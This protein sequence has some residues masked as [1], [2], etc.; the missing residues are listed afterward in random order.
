LA[1]LP[2]LAFIHLP[3][4][5]AA[6]SSSTAPE[7]IL[8]LGKRVNRT[9]KGATNLP[10]S[11]FETPQSVSV[12]D[13]EY[14]DSFGFDTV[15][16]VLKLTTGVNVEEVETDRTYY[17]ARGF[18][19]KSMQVD[20]L[21]LPFNWNVVGA[22]D[23]VVYDRVE[24]IRG[25]NGLLTG[26]GNPS[27]TINYVRKRPTNEFTSSTEVWVDSEQK[28]RVEAD[29][30]GPLTDSG[31]WAARVVAARQTGGS[32]LD[33]YDN[34]R[35]TLYGVLDGQLGH[36]TTLTLG[37]TNQ[38]NDSRGVLWGALPLLY[39]DGGQTDFDAGTS[40][41]MNWT[42][43]E[44]RNETAFV[45]ITHELGAWELKSV[46]THNSYEEPSELF[47]VYASPGLDRTTGLGLYGWPGK[48]EAASD[49]LL[50]DTTL[51][52]TFG[53]GGREHD[54][55]VGFNAASA[56]HS[57]YEF[58]A[59]PA[60]PA[61]GA[62]PAFPG[63]RGDEIARPTFG[64]GELA[65]DWTDDVRRLY[66]AARF[67][68][69]DT[70][71][72]IA[73]FNAIDL[74]SDG[75]NFGE[76]MDQDESDVS[77]YVGMTFRF[78]D[79]AQL[80]ASY[81]DIFEPQSELDQNLQPLGAAIG[82]SYELGLKAEVFERRLLASLSIFEA[83]QDNYAEYAGFDVGSGLSIYEGVD[84]EATGFELEMAGQIGESWHLFAGYTDLTLETPD[85]AAARTFVPRETLKF[86][87][88]FRPAAVSDLEVGGTVKWQDEIYLD[89]AGGRIGQSG[90]A[91]LAAHVR[92]QVS[93]RFELAL[94]V[95]NLTDEKYLTSLYWDQAFYAAPRSAAFSF[96]IAY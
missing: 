49:R 28:R 13:R 93:R 59:D 37:Y 86:G 61:W 22:L 60:D 85:G 14:L 42:A 65:G 25:A 36:R 24:V 51:V 41:S 5:A 39:T 91:V 4:T 18:D 16:D 35:T 87:T 26:T 88:R 31:A 95:N 1:F 45:E 10:L 7:E 53:L 64:A 30:S 71:D 12:I 6:Q 76:P 48:Y 69:G 74:K 40:T 46:V 58:P 67:S 8:I 70:F 3:G 81:S 47:Y 15:N 63:W 83:R 11:L 57:Y 56:D 72:L 84:V 29:F 79:N 75:Y 21:G 43:W 92:Y 80:Y 89:T 32:Y 19:I 78:R 33:L 73:G 17:T 96:R 27:G 23:T 44:T 34:D 20:G 66:S 90:Y 68:L 94:N 54:L 62:L 2:V 52:G 38:D 77:P 9:S 50:L 82:K 55:V